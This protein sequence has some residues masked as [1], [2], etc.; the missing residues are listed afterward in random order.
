MLYR[1]AFIIEIHVLNKHFGWQVVQFVL[2]SCI[3]TV[4]LYHACVFITE[5]HNGGVEAVWA[6][7]IGFV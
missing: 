6:V 7:L 2:G 1:A 5:K 3:E 4:S